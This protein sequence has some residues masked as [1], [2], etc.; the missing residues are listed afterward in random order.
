MAGIYIHI[1]F[2]KQACNYCDFH[3]TTYLKYADQVVKAMVHEIT[4]RKQYL[5]HEP[6]ETIYMGGGTPSAVSDANIK[7]LITSVKDTYSVIEDPEI[8]IE[9]NPDDIS[10]DK[11]SRYLEF[12]FNR[13]SMG[14]QS[15]RDADLK[16]LNRRHTSS[17]AIESIEILLKQGFRNISID[18]IY[19]LPG[20]TEN[21]WEGNLNQAFRS[22]INHLSAY[23][24]SYEPGTV[25]YYRK[26]K[27]SIQAP[28]EEE[29]EKQYN[30]LI[31]AAEA[32]GFEQYEISNFA[33][34]HQYSKHNTSYWTGKK[35]LGIGPSAHSFNG[36]ERRW[37]N[38]GI[39]SYTRKI[40]EGGEYYESELINTTMGFNEYIMTALRTMWGI[41]LATVKDD[42]GTEYYTEI[43]NR[44]VEFIRNENMI[45][46]R[47]KLVLTTKGKFIADYII[48]ELFMEQDPSVQ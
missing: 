39:S 40:G 17:E 18:L 43:V 24:L 35:Y 29:S 5:D 9:V 46:D 45:R 27:N 12:G 34:D 16:L 6:V 4:S 47:D 15:F 22:G 14:V 36:L 38:K 11:A 2:C 21:Q 25:M 44:S 33:R 42:F 10:G 8:T 23:H 30:L 31:T 3:F 26:I 28:K 20:Q 48:A 1:P 37:N 32:K 19:G 41:N 7:K 13:V